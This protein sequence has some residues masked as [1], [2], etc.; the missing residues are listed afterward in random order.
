[1]ALVGAVVVILNDRDEILILKRPA[2]VDWAPDKWALP[3]GKLEH[4]ESA[5]TAAIR[6]SKEETDLDVRNLKIINLKVDSPIAPFYTR[7]YSGTVKIDFEHTDW[8][9]TARSKI[10]TY[11]LAPSVLKLY[12]WVLQNG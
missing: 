8:T 5:L 11:D 12:E 3:G 2:F 6:E 7:Q 1:M 9:W 10:E 4:N